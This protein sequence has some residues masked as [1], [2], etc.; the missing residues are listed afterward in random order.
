MPDPEQNENHSNG[1]ITEEQYN[2]LKGELEQ[3][4]AKVNEQVAQATQPLTERI[5]SLEEELRTNAQAAEQQKAA[6]EEKDKGFASLSA[7][8]E[9]AVNAYRDLVLKSNPLLPADMITGATV[10]EINASVEKANGIIG[11]VKEGLELQ[12]H[13]QT[14]QTTIPAGSPG[15]APADLSNMTT[16]EKINY[17]LDQAK[18][19]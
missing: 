6:A 13:Q 16:R 7:Q 5:A 3:E 17:G 14:Q 18:K 15:R 8:H 1:T 10:E 19:K 11:R 9:G 4:R 12:N 2:Q